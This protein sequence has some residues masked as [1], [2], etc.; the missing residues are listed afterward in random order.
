MEQI[1]H[2]DR[3]EEE[4]I[5][6]NP[7]QKE[8][9]LKVAQAIFESENT[10]TIALSRFEVGLYYGDQI[11]V[12]DETSEDGVRMELLEY[13][14][15]QKDFDEYVINQLLFKHIQY[16]YP[17]T[18]AGGYIAFRFCIAKH[19]AD[20]KLALVNKIIELG[21]EDNAPQCDEYTQTVCPKCSIP[22][23]IYTVM[24]FH[25]QYCGNCGYKLPEGKQWFYGQQSYI[26]L[27]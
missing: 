1:S 10:N 15:A 19:A 26:R 9:S 5:D 12:E 23:S 16:V 24:D 27:F 11:V 21:L 17:D 13:N 22:C 20:M 8:V 7:P 6:L 18:G 4:I 2:Y 25:Y 14:D 3:K